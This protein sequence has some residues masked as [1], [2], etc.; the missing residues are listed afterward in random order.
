M[1]LVANYYSLNFHVM[2]QD[3]PPI[4]GARLE[5]LPFGVPPFELRLTWTVEITDLES[6]VDQ[7]KHRGISLNLCESPFWSGT[8]IE[9]P[10]ERYFGVSVVDD[11]EAQ[12]DPRDQPIKLT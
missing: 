8:S 1:K 12:I 3:K 9:Q 11:P 6:L 7:V 10:G 2:E 5:R 4:A